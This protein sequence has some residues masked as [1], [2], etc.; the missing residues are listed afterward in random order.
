MGGGITMNQVLVHRKDG[1]RILVQAENIGT[2][3]KIGGAPTA[4]EPPLTLDQLV[5]I[6]V[7]PAL[8]MFPG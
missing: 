7:D 1:T 4:S 3:G 8:T 6:G 5:A 2:S